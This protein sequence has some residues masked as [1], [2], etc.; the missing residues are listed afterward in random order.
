MNLYY[1]PSRV[2]SLGGVEPLA[3]AT[4]TKRQGALNWQQG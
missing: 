4:N 3:R 2:G 1:D